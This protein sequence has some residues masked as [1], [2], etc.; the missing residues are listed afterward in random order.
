MAN[1]PGQ[2]GRRLARRLGNRRW[3]SS[4]H[5]CCGDSSS[6]IPCHRLANTTCFHRRNNRKE[7]RKMNASAIQTQD[8]V[9]RTN[10]HMKPEMTPG[11]LV[12]LLQLFEGAGIEVWLDGGWAVNA[13]LGEQTRPHKDVDIILRVSDLRKLRNL[14]RSKGFEIQPGGT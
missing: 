8:G 13:V 2:V 11:A 7:R 9:R 12:D 5:L 14:L 6:H 4:P 10:R 1:M 3:R